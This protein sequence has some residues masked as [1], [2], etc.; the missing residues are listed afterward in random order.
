M[1]WVRISKVTWTTCSNDDFDDD[2]NND[3]GDD[4]DNDDDN[5]D[6]DTI[7]AGGGNQIS[8]VCSCQWADNEDANILMMMVGKYVLGVEFDV[9]P[10]TDLC[11]SL[12]PVSM[13]KSNVPTGQP[14]S[15]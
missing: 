7:E 4:N 5:D 8:N 3:D 1:S 15:A 10:I 2:D 13:P 9:K 12:I 6:V 14:Q 11:Q